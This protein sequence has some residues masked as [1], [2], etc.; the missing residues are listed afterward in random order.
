MLIESLP[1]NFQPISEQDVSAVGTPL[2]DV[3][4]TVVSQEDWWVCD[5]LEDTSVFPDNLSLDC[6][7]PPTEANVQVEAVQ[8]RLAD[9]EAMWVHLLTFSSSRVNCMYRRTICTN[10]PFV[11]SWP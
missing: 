5:I 10:L 4:D 11:I 8:T 3:K 7:S 6:L 9:L 2:L 1:E